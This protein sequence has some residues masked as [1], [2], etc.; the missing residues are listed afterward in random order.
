MEKKIE[1]I[2]S[3]R[4]EVSLET[5]NFKGADCMIASKAFEEALGVKE[6]DR[7]TSAYFQ[8]SESS[9]QVKA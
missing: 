5:K 6:S 8:Q 9:Q 2:V 4:G 1:I 3:P 7:K